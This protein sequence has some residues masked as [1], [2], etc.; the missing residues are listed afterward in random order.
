MCG[1]FVRKCSV[2]EIKSEFGA[3]ACPEGEIKWA[4]EPSYNVAP[5]QNVLG[6]INN[7]GANRIASFRWGLVPFW[8]KDA[9][10]GNRMINA[11][12]ETLTEK[13]AF[14]RIFKNQ[15]CLIVADGFYEW[16]KLDEKSK[17]PMYIHLR[18]NRP[19][20]LAGLY[21]TWKSPKDGSVL[22]TCTI[23]T[24]T[25]N[26]LLAPIHDRMPAIIARE[27]RNA[28]LD[29]GISDPQ[30]LMPLLKPYDSKDMEAYEVSR[31]VNK[32]EYNRPDCVKPF[33]TDNS[34]NS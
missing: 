13:P 14:S 11:R 1:R 19:F 16:K 21:S 27:H 22:T 23:I 31:R 17:M 30:A 24:T 34:A 26:E 7:E 3:V 10:I 18:A 8:A 6:V 9:S 2:D 25:P 33:K 5:M 32:P 28:W 29:G 12:A 4:F 15:R 20:G